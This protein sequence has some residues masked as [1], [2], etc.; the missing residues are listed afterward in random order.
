M[1]YAVE[2]SLKASLMEEYGV[3][4]LTEL[5]ECLSL[6][7]HHMIDVQTHKLT[8]LMSWA[9]VEH[10]RDQPTKKIWGI[11]CKWSV[12]W[13]YNPL[14]PGESECQ[15]FFDAVGVIRKFVRTNV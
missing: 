14:D 9:E 15:K 8:A 13:R 4:S 11:C 3:V 2:C 10:R 5:Q 1:G 7:Y 12:E 6:R